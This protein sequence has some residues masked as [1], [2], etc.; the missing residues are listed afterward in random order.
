[1]EANL[2][3]ISSLPDE[4]APDDSGLAPHGFNTVLKRREFLSG[5]LLLTS[6]CVISGLG[7]IGCRVPNENPGELSLAG[8]ELVDTLDFADDGDIPMNTAVGTELD[9][10]LFFDHSEL[11]EGN[12]VT[13][14][15][16]FYIRTRASEL[17]DPKK[18]WSVKLG[19][20]K[21]QTHISAK[22][23]FR[24]GVSQGMHLM[25]CAGNSRGGRFGMIS[26]ADWEGLPVSTVLNRVGFEDRRS[27]ILISGFDTY[28]SLSAT[29]IPGASWIFSLEELSKSGAFIATKMNGSALTHDHGAPVRLVVP[30]WYGCCCVKWVDEITPVGDDISATSQMR[31]YASRT[32]QSGVPD[33]AREYEPAMIDP[34]AMPIRTERWK[35]NGRIEYRIIGIQW[36]GT[37]PIKSLRISF[38]GGTEWHTV[39]RLNEKVGDTWALWAHTWSPKSPGNYRIRLKVDDP[40]V[41]TRRLDKGYYDRV[42]DIPAD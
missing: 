5:S 3:P 7:M 13:P 36:G 19:N 25:E 12:M 30:G 33:L 2:E 23:L 17:L 41:R 34:A 8:G 37:Q 24:N 38:N 6:G 4:I 32:H 16:R 40:R 11:S 29:S 22:E 18:P 1:M 27:R 15:D 10:R 9:G 42:I 28:A 26:V 20:G 35:V 39:D 14:T 21:R 31:E